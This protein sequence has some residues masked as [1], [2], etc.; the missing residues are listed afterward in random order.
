[1]P[2]ADMAIVIGSITSEKFAGAA[3]SSSSVPC[4]RSRWRAAPAA[5]LV[6]DQIPITEAPSDA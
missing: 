5:V 2:I 1:M 3:T 4:Q 6:A